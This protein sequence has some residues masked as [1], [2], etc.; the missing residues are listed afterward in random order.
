MER[1]AGGLAKIIHGSNRMLS[2]VQMMCSQSAVL[3]T[4]AGVCADT[5]LRPPVSS[6]GT[7]GGVGGR[8]RLLGWFPGDSHRISDSVVRA[9]RS[10]GMSG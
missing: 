9:L 2:S 3:A 6:L 5:V 4:E 7:R 8:G 10:L 1:R